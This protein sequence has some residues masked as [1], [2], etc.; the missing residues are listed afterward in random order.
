MLRYKR[1]DWSN[2][3]KLMRSA[4]TPSIPYRYNTEIPSSSDLYSRCHVDDGQSRLKNY[5][6]YGHEEKFCVQ[7]RWKCWKV[8]VRMKKQQREDLFR[9]V[10]MRRRKI[11]NAWIKFVQLKKCKRENFDSIATQ[12]RGMQR[13]SRIQ[14]CW[15]VIKYQFGLNEK[16][17]RNIIKS[18]SKLKLDVLRK[19]KLYIKKRKL[20]NERKSI[21]QRHIQQDY[22]NKWK[23]YI[24]LLLR[25]R[26]EELRVRKWLLYRALDKLSTYTKDNLRMNELES[27]IYYK[28]AQL[29]IRQ[30]FNAWRLLKKY[31]KKKLYSRKKYMQT[32]LARVL[33]LWKL[34]CMKQVKDEFMF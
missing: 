17:Q 7:S 18:K 9:C 5:R 10:S 32:L 31:Q 21:M 16:I 12:I 28:H 15:S 1:C 23:K 3:D 27:Q 8:Y 19:W 2:F 26:L 25:N 4:S 34:V 14:S 24:W 33:C 29:L 11:L 6:I 22:F 20:K 30:N 13:N